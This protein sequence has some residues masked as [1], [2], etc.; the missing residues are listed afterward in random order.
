MEFLPKMPAESTL[1][2]NSLF[3]PNSL[4]T[5]SALF[6]GWLQHPYV[7][8]N[9]P[10]M[11]NR[12][13]CLVCGVS[14]LI[15][16]SWKDL[17]GVMWHPLKLGGQLSITGMQPIFHWV[18]TLGHENHHWTINTINNKCLWTKETV[19]LPSVTTAPS[20]SKTPSRTTHPG[21]TT[22][23]IDPPR[24]RMSCSGGGDSTMAGQQCTPDSS[25]ENHGCSWENGGCNASSSC[26]EAAPCAL[27]GRTTWQ[28][29]SPYGTTKSSQRKQPLKSFPVFILHYFQ[30]N[31]PVFH[32]QLTNPPPLR[33][34]KN[35]T[36][37]PPTPF[38]MVQTASA[39]A[40]ESLLPFHANLFSVQW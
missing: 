36:G 20:R 30:A 6:L 29:P 9:P 1:A 23:C 28:T 3:F 10:F 32:Y 26:S 37:K 14:P 13:Q 35:M 5:T 16:L 21:G 15:L 12:K 38:F 24:P 31:S 19:N 7:K 17:P 11:D 22:G 4:N 27:S 40:K 33:T 18:N 2:T 34:Q 25:R 39:D 8:E